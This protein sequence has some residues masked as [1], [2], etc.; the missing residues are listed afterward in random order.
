MMRGPS[1]PM[2]PPLIIALAMTFPAAAPPSRGHAPDPRDFD[3]VIAPILIRSCLDCHSGP[4]PK[5]QLDLTSRRRAM[6]GGASGAVI[7][8]AK[9]EESLL[10]EY[11]E[12]DEMPPKR[13]LPTGD[14][15]LIREWIVAG[16]PWG[17]DPIDSFRV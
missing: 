8:P 12:G 9:P 11:V 16:A 2:I 1:R 5:G 13:P 4:E 6:K 14:K 17:T 3:Q 10:W 7:V 15:A